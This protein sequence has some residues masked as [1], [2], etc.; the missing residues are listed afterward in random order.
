[1]KSNH[2]TNKTQVEFLQPNKG[3]I[4]ETKLL[5]NGKVNFIR[6]DERIV[7]RYAV[8]RTIMEAAKELDLPENEIVVVV[9]HVVLA[10]FM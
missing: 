5:V 4:T 1:M 7:G 9:K 6:D 3:L 2:L 10:M 8:G